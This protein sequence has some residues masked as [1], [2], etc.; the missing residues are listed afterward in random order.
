MS[1]GV[2]RRH[3]SDAVLLW[4]RC[5]PTAVALSRP[6]AWD[7]LP[8]FRSFSFFLVFSGPHLQH[9]EVLRLEV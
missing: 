5:R 9:M 2:G 1:C 3:G 8:S 6:L 7:L 4:L